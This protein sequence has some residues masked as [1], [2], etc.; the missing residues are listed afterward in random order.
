MQVDLTASS[1]LDATGKPLHLAAFY[2]SYGFSSPQHPLHDGRS[3]VVS[4][5]E[6]AHALALYKQDIEVLRI[7]MSLVAGELNLIKP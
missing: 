3:E 5:S 7:P 1:I 4:A 6:D 2:G